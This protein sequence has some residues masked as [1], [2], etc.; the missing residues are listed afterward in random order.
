MHPFYRVVFAAALC[1]WINGAQA[2]VAQSSENPPGSS[3][4]PLAT[5]PGDDPTEDTKGFWHHTASG[6][7]TIWSTGGSDVFV[8]GYIWHS[9]WRYSDEQ[10]NRYN[11]AAW[12][13]G[14]GRTLATR[15]NRPRTL[16]GILSADSYS[17]VQYMVGYA[18]RAKWRPGGKAFSLGGGY[19]AMLIGRYDKAAYVPLPVALPLASLGTD[20]FEV[21]GAYVPG[22]D[23]GFFFLKLNVGSSRQAHD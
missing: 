15:R 10:R 17:H 23:V 18:W 4:E 19:T 3:G 13:L 16:Y 11:A 14:Y 21:M 12:G 6:M 22:F 8:P 5:A 1:A 9:P 20:R 2:T 7:K